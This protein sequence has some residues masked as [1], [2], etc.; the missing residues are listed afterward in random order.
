MFLSRQMRYTS[1]M[2]AT[3]LC[4][5]PVWVE[6]DAQQ[7]PQP[8]GIVR[9]AIRLAKAGHRVVLVSRVGRDALGDQLLEQLRQAQ[10]NTLFVQRHFNCCTD[11]QDA[12]EI[13]HRDPLCRLDVDD[14]LCSQA[15]FLIAERV[16]IDSQ[17]SDPVLL[18]VLQLAE[19]YQVHVEFADAA[20]HRQVRN[21]YHATASL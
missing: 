8:T 13:L 9:Q 4:I 6:F 15:Q 7:V 21:P 17:V 12:Q 20:Q 14:V 19:Q 5:G 16:I 11:H 2:S 18:Q 10:V 3:I 1:G